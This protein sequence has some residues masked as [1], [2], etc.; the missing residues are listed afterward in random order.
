MIPHETEFG[1][2]IL[3]ERGKHQLAEIYV[4][5]GQPAIMISAY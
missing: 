3:R 5:F 2:F 1:L 4:S